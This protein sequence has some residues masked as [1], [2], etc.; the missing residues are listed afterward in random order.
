MVIIFIHGVRP[1]VTEKQ[2]THYNGHHAVAWWVI[3][4]SPDFFGFSPIFAEVLATMVRIQQEVSILSKSWERDK[5][6]EI[7]IRFSPAFAA[8]VRDS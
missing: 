2:N 3:L 4:N 6:P 5:M 7:S 1:S 8:G